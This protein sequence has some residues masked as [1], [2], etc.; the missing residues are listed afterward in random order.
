MVRIIMCAIL[1]L[2]VLLIQVTA[3]DASYY[4]SKGQ[5][6]DALYQVF[7]QF[8]TSTAGT[9]RLNSNIELLNSSYFLPNGQ[10]TQWA[11]ASQVLR[12]DATYSNSS[13]LQELGYLSGDVYTSLLGS[14][15]IAN[16][17]YIRQD[18][19][20]MSSEDLIWTETVNAKGE[21]VLQ[22]WYSESGLNPFGGEDHF[23]A[24]LIEDD[25]LLS[26]FNEQYGTD[27]NTAT[28]D[29]WM[30]AFEMYNLGSADYTDLVAIVARP[31]ANPVPIPASA[32]LFLS[33]LVSLVGFSKR[34][35]IRK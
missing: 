14:N 31:G 29:V 15:Q 23:L 1:M 28:D 5:S 35:A 8:F 24:F 16:S 26:V 7:N 2:P 4:S 3:A 21:A 6:G 32:F 10:D 9:N 19:S 34:P 17:Q 20:F 12:V 22:R 25:D 33:A 13:F 18:I 30:I 27:Y 11:Q